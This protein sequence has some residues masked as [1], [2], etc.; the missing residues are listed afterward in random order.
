[1]AKIVEQ[2]CIKS[3]EISAENGDHFKV[4]QGKTYTTTV[5]SD[6]EYVTVFSNYWVKAPKEN[7]V[8]SECWTQRQ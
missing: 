6:S 8:V 5:P 1:M 3:W 2:L 4:V 7:F